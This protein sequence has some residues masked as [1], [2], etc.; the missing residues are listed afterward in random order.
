MKGWRRLLIYLGISLLAAIAG[1]FAGQTSIGTQLEARTYDYRFLLK[2]LFPPSTSAPITILAIDEKSLEHIPDPLMLWQRHFAE[3]LTHLTKADAAVIALDILF[4]S[5]E[6]F[7]PEGQASLATA[8]IDAGKKNLPVIVA[9]RVRANSV[10]PVPVQLQLAANAFREGF[11]YVNLTADP[12]DFVR[13]Q[14]LQDPAMHPGFALA[15]ANAFAERTDR[16]LTFQAR[17]EAALIDFMPRETFPR[18]SFYDALEA[19]N[20]D[21]TDFFKTRFGGR[22]VLIGRVSAPGGED[23]H[24][25]P[26]YYS[27]SPDLPEGSRTPGIDIHAN[28]IAMLIDNR[29]ILELTAFQHFLVVGLTGLAFALIWGYLRRFALGSS[30]ALAIGY[31]VFVIFM[32]LRGTWVGTVAPVSSATTAL[33]LTL[34]ANY[35]LEG[36]EK[37]RIRNLFKGYVSDTVIAQLLESPE[38]VALSGERRRIAVLFSDIK[39]FTTIS[40]TASPERVVQLLNEYFAV[41]VEI[42][43]S[44]GGTVNSLMGDGIMAIFGAPIKDGDAALH[45]VTAAQEMMRALVRVNES[46]RGKGYEPIGIG[47]GINSG[48]AV[49]GNM[50]SARKMEYTAIGDVVNTAARIEGQTRSIAA[51]ILISE[52]AYRWIDG[53]IAAEFVKD[54]ALK[55]KGQTVRL[56]SVPWN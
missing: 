43:Q 3:V 25:T 30:L 36:K 47:V 46:L 2:E 16:P 37:R 32:F 15:I 28:T 18:V 21:N 27:S 44:R 41:M 39:G 54:A 45:A 19:A 17:T 8:L 48:E 53:R 6:R 56:Y 33:V 13:R 1:W 11:A 5:I 38:G 4:S 42:I 10:D 26:L 35:F 9:S 22:I 23:L 31:A 29:P 55:G 34:G 50:G 40:E 51:D 7:D 20:S 24:S 52:D 14:T 12:D 49:I